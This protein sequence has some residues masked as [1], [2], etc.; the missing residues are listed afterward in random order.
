MVLAA[1][2]LE[3]HCETTC[4][5]IRKALGAEAAAQAVGN[6]AQQIIAGVPPIGV[7][8]DAQVLDVD[9]GHGGLRFLR[10][11]HSQAGGEP[12]AEQ[13]SLGETRERVEIRK[14][15]DGIFLLKILEGI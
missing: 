9:Y 8:D 6:H 3:Q 5:E 11:A 10:L 7:V 2:V 12:F 13:D 4:A 14:E 1:G 15:L